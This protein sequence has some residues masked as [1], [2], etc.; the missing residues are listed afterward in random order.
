MPASVH[1]PPESASV[2]QKMLP[3]ESVSRTPEPVHERMVPIWAPPVWIWSPPRMVEEAEPETRSVEEAWRRPETP[4]APET[5][6]DACEMKPDDPKVASPPTRR[7]EDAWSG[8]PATTSP[9]E[10]VEEAWETSP[11]ARV[12]RESACKVE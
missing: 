6:D 1:A 11:A 8:A 10:N 5:V 12:A 9:E 4:S 7:V 2:P 3:D